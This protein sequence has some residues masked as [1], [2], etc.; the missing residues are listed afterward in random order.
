MSKLTPAAQEHV[1]A[2]IGYRRQHQWKKAAEA[3]ASARQLTPDFSEGWFWEAVSLDNRG[4]EAEAIPRYQQA[5]RLG[6]PE[7]LVPM[8]LTWLAS[9]CSKVGATGDARRWLEQAEASGGYPPETEFRDLVAEIGRRIE[10][11]DRRSR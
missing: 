5:L 1:D 9:S 2:G 8:A 7:P 10:R 4:Q 11:Q 3:F 6:L